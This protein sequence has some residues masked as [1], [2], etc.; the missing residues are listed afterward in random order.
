MA[1]ENDDRLNRILQGWL[2]RNVGNSDRRALAERISHAVEAAPRLPDPSSG[3]R[4]RGVPRAAWVIVAAAVLLVGV[5]VW[6][7]QHTPPAARPDENQAAQRLLA[8]LDAGELQRRLALLN[9]LDT[10]FERRWQWMVECGDRVDMSVATAPQSI[11]TSGEVA[12]RVT[13]LVRDDPAEAFRVREKT[14]LLTREEQAVETVLENDV[15]QK[16]YFWSYPIDQGLFTYDLDLQI[17]RP[18]K[19]SITASGVVPSGKPTKILSFEQEGSEYRV[20]LLLVPARQDT[21]SGAIRQ[22]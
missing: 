4:R 6:Q 20:Y 21:S 11:S 18:G 5:I 22:L 12:V 7:I 17:T 13:V 9:E 16:L 1:R 14:F 10:L 3:P 2:D 15:S 19:L 8:E